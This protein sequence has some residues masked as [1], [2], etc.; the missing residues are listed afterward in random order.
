[1]K[2]M[3]RFLGIIALI[4]IIGFAMIGCKDG[5]ERPGDDDTGTQVNTSALVA[6]ISEA[7][8]G[9]ENTVV[10]ED[11]NDVP[12]GTFWVTNSVMTT[13]DAAIAAA[14]QALSAKTQQAVDSAVNTLDTAIN[15]FKN[16][17]QLGK[18]SSVNK[19][20]LNVKIAEAESIKTGVVV[21]TSAENV[22]QGMY[23]V[24]TQVMTT[25]ETAI[26]NAKQVKETATTQQE[27]DNAVETL[28]NAINTFTSARQT[29]SKT[30]GFTEDE[31]AD[32]IAM[33]NAAK[34]GVSVSNANGDDISPLNFWVSQSYLTDLENAISAAQTA[35]GNIDSVYLALV[36]DLNNFNEAKVQGTIPDKDELLSLIDEVDEIRTYVA[37]AS[38]AEQA[39]YDSYWA[40]QEQ[41]APLN[42]AY[43]NAVNAYSD[44]NATKIE[45]D[46]LT[47]VLENAIATF[48]SAYIGNGL[49]QKQNSVTITGLSDYNGYEISAALFVSL[50][51]LQLDVMP[52]IFGEGYITNDT[53]EVKLY[54]D[55]F[56]AWIGTG[57]YYI[58]I[59]LYVS[60]DEL[61]II[62]VNRTAVNFTSNPNPTLTFSV[63]SK[64]AFGYK[65]GDIAEEL[66]FDMTGT[67]TMDE[68]VEMISEGGLSTYEDFFDYFGIP[69][70]KNE[71]MTSQ[72]NGSDT[73]N[74]NTWVYVEVPFEFLMEFE[75]DDPDFPPVSYTQLTFN[76]WEDGYI[77]NIGEREQWFRFVATANTQYL[78]FNPGQMYDCWVELYDEYGNNVQ[79]YRTNNNYGENIVNLYDSYLYAYCYVSTW[80]TYYIRV[81]PYFSNNYGD[82][83]FAFNTSSSA[84]VEISTPIQI[85]FSGPV[86]EEINV[87][88][89][90]SNVPQLRTVRIDM[91]DSYG[92]GWNANGALRIYINGD[93]LTDARVASGTSNNT[94]DFNVV[95]GD[96]V[97]IYWV[98]GTGTAYQ[99]ENSFIV[100]Y[101]DAPP[102]PA[103]TTSNNN[104]WNGA[105][106]LLYRLR[107]V[108]GGPTGGVYLNGVA[109]NTLLGSFT[110]NVSA[111]IDSFNITSDDTIE[112]SAP[113]V[114]AGY[115][116]I[117]N[118]AFA[119]DTNTL[120]V[121]GS[122]LPFG[123]NSI[124]LVIY[125]QEG[126]VIVPY[127]KTIS[128]TVTP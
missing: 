18:M 68:W 97:Q 116:W 56:T 52:A 22:A 3:L 4:A 38:S 86:D 11:G 29:G 72:F 115:R 78:H 89:V 84:P 57:S 26:N 123:P 33:A 43:S 99:H 20:A 45:V 15:V 60:G 64:Y 95:T 46:E 6:K 96:V 102:S 25:F 91:F 27:A 54:D 100:Y 87:F 70:Y 104:T 14:T 120:T 1:M 41:W 107:T 114:Y 108:S 117:V 61:P 31:L 47:T 50:D 55:S 74:A 128:F 44:P 88:I 23:W 34:T 17:R 9:K 127:S 82:Y 85:V 81:Y 10:S 51:D 19:T 110:L 37:I 67:M 76:Q 49:G 111:I 69:L 48:T 36:T 119:G 40:T 94:Y 106:A 105:N 122:S 62:R 39:P 63:F 98:V 58:V 71:A 32:L 5:S 2:T 24:T 80:Q 83:Q 93:H 121:D 16:A 77:P 28:N 12:L 21:N 7:N 90:D 13:F 103:F 118:N 75:I 112:L 125:K 30:S 65:F 35:S 101:T 79:L 92:D 8:A 53:A 66:G 126:A 59:V 124:T 109:N 73:V 42:T 113:E